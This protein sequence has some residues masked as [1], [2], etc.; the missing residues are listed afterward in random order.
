MKNM[1]NERATFAYRQIE[2]I[3]YKK[4][5]FRSLSRRFPTMV[6]T[7]GLTVAVAFLF[8]KKDKNKHINE[9]TEMY[10]IISEWLSNKN[11]HSDDKSDLMNS[12]V[13][14]ESDTLRLATAEVMALLVWIKRFAEGMFEADVKVGE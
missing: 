10:R 9:H 5:E 7:N 4:S 2:K 14:M 12:I 11:N 1:N 13:K 6:H 8:A 3:Q